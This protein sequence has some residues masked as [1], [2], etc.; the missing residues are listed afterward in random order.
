MAI[1]VVNIAVAI[2]ISV[3]TIPVVVLPLVV[4]TSS[5]GRLDAQF[6]I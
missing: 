3:N 4:I 1:E 2:T 6:E 5:V